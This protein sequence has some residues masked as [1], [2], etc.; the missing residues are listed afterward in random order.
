MTVAPTMGAQLSPSIWEASA[1]DSSRL[2]KEGRLRHRLNHFVF[3]AGQ[4]IG[5]FEGAG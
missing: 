3:Q 1:I 2:G 5:D 4:D